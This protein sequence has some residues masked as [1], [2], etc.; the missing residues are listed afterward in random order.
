MGGFS[1]ILVAGGA[2]FIGSHIVDR[3]IEQ[4]IEV[5]VLDS[6]YSGKMENLANHK[7]NKN[8]QFV[9]GDIRN[10]RTVKRVIK[11][12][13]AVFNEA[14]IVGIPRS[15]ENPILANDVNV[16]GTLALLEACLESNVTRF[17][18]ASSASIY[19]DTETLPIE[20]T[21]CP[22]PVSPYA[23]AELASENYARVFHSIYGLETVCLRYFNVYGPR[24]S[25]NV[26]SGVI[27]IFMSQLID[28]KQPTIF[29]NGKQTRDFVYVE[30]VVEANML[31]ITKKKAAGET[32]NIAT[33]VPSSLNDLARNLQNEMT[34]QHL[35]PIYKPSRKGD[36]R[37][38]Y[39]S[40]EKARRV[41][42]YEPRYDLRRGI[43]KLCK[44]FMESRR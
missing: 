9:R 6:L 33:G 38:S 7:G 3:L 36:V 18:Q 11:D 14:A 34:K 42:G 23:V 30:D 44:W 5:V 15:T 28:N 40:I 1:S 8:Y 4:D 17:V 41:L 10:H 19:G 37:F 32:F 13:D 21:F 35:K 29:G 25:P 26:H 43:A 16:G 27:P 22:N 2:G 31:A 39:A 20:E 12:V 24:Q